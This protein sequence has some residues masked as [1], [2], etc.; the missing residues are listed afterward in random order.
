MKDSITICPIKPVSIYIDKDYLKKYLMEF[1]IYLDKNA[2]CGFSMIQM[3]SNEETLI[4]DFL[5]E[6]PFGK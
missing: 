6:M 2:C 5:K 3:H 1:L 4:D